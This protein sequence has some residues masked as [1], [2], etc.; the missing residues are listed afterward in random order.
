MAASP[1]RQIHLRKRYETFLQSLIFVLVLALIYLVASGLGLTKGFN[2]KKESKRIQVI[3]DFEDPSMDLDWAT[4]GYVKMETSTDNLTH[5][6]HSAMAHLP[7]S[8]P[9]Y[10]TPTLGPNAPPT[11]TPAPRPDPQPEGQ[12]CATVM[13]KGKV[14]PTPVV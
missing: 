1:L 2:K 12:G 11:A 14:S 9:V 13:P 3:N 4:G 5:G 10:P 7:D 6:K 8:R